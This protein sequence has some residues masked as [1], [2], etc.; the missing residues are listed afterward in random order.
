MITDKLLARIKPGYDY[1]LVRQIQPF[2]DTEDNTTSRSY[3]LS[4]GEIVA[5]AENL[6]SSLHQTVI[7]S[8]TSLWFKLGE[9]L[10]HFVHLDD[11]VGSIDDKT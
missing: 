5:A 4:Y 7:Y 8:K 2:D 3:G 10:F 9:N 11:L 6:K 1:V